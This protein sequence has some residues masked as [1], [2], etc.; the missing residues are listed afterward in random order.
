MK[1]EI[2]AIICAR[3]GSKGIPG[4]NLKQICGLPM[5]QYTIDAAKESSFISRIILSSDDQEI[6]DYCKTKNLEVP[7]LRPQELA[8]DQA[9][10]IDVLKHAILFLKEKENYYPKYVLLLQPTSPLR[11]SKHID[12]ALERLIELDA[13][14]IVSV[15]EVPHNF[16]PG[17][18]MESE[19]V[20]LRHC[21]KI[22]EKNL[23]RQKK[24]KFYGR[25]GPAVL[26]FKSDCLLKG[27]TVYGS[28]IL[29]YIMQKD[30]SVDIDDDFD[31]RIAECFFKK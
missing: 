11:T 3:G 10:M 30:E 25:N 15:V 27:N 9:A 14:S 18:L 31:F 12:E 19:G 17:S 23:I 1:K 24:P 20:F 2:L 28:K 16:N 4:K 8:T 22:D 13:D 5:I 26:A 7:F 29:S 21:V 6:I